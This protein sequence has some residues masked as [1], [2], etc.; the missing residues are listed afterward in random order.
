MLRTGD[1]CV[2]QVTEVLG[3]APS[4][5]SAHLRELK[6]GRLITEH[7]EGRWVHLSLSKSESSALWIRCAL[8][9]LRD[10]PQVASDDALV[11]ELRGLGVEVLCRLGLDE[12]R[13]S[14]ARKSQGN[15]TTEEAAT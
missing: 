5:V 11:G 3:L 7:K 6:L 15:T 4:T 9:Q 2:C 14:V 13:N 10:D 12:A 1:L 8:E